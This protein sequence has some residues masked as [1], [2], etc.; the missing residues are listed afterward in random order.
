MHWGSL[1]LVASSRDSGIWQVTIKNSKAP[2]PDFREAVVVCT[3]YPVA[4]PPLLKNDEESR[5]D[6]RHGRSFHPAPNNELGL[7]L[8]IL[9]PPERI[10]TRQDLACR[11]IVVAESKIEG[12]RMRGSEERR[13]QV[14]A[15][16]L[17]Y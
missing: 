11:A 16:G 8:L 5:G 15:P 4:P 13:R 1:L 14:R 17:E 6:I 10:K 9:Q 2:T 7:E 12:S 3:R